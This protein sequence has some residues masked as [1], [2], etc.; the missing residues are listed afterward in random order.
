M[1]CGG[2][3]RLKGRIERLE[4]WQ[5]WET[6]AETIVELCGEGGEGDSEAAGMLGEAMEASVCKRVVCRFPRAIGKSFP[7]ACAPTSSVCSWL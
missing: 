5:R 3:R 6:D 4:S 7:R 2:M 1:A